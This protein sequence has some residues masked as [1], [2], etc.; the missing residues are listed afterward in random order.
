M[1]KITVSLLSFLAVSSAFA[2]EAGYFYTGVGVGQSTVSLN[3]DDFNTNSSPSPS[4]TVDASSKTKAAYNLNV[5]YQFTPNLAVE[6]SYLNL[7]SP[8]YGY[9]YNAGSANSTLKL[10][11]LG[12]AG[13]GKWQVADSVALLGGVGVVS[14]TASRDPY[15]SWGTN[16]ASTSKT[17]ITSQITIGAEYAINK[18]LAVQA[19]YTSYGVMGDADSVGR[20]TPSAYTL[21]LQYSFR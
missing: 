11:G 16:P 6:V 3:S 1:K 17:G 7:G 15:H 14:Y 8:V 2:Q 9:T 20:I 19:R 13:I 21:G 12:V 18:Q 10:T 4:T 5:G